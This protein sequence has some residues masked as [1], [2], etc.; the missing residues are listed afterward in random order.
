MQRRVLCFSWM[1]LMKFMGKGFT[2]SDDIEDPEDT[3]EV[4]VRIILCL[5]SHFFL[6]FFDEMSH[7]KLRNFLTLEKISQDDCN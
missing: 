7:P 3:C 1:Q 2:V 6:D 5:R 4:R